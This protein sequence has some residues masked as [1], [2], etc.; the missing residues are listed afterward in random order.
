MSDRGIHPDLL[1]E[2]EQQMSLASGTPVKPT[3]SRKGRGAAAAADASPPGDAPSDEPTAVAADG[4][5]D[6]TTPAPEPAQ[7]PTPLEWL[8]QVR[9]ASDPKEML[10]L[11]TRNLPKEDLSRDDVLAG[12]IGDLGN[13]RARKL[14][15]D[16]ERS[17]VEKA[18]AEAY[19]KGDLY[20]LGQ[21][22]AAELEQQRA[23]LKAQTEAELNPYMQG[24]RQ[25]QSTLPEAVQ[26]AVQGRTY[27]DFPAYLRAVQEAAIRHGVEDEIGKRTNGLQKAALSQTVGSEQSPELDGGPAQA[28]REITDAQIA[29]MTLEEYDRHF[30]NQG[31][32][33]PGV[34]VRLERGIDLR[35][36]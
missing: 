4:S 8:D 17:R 31:R 19:E 5:G 32:P 33:K 20:T 15:E 22:N 9:N 35:Q 23:A 28:Y 13:Q 12:M 14:L 25:F 36:R 21:L 6:D 29:A 1:E 34:R 27:P 10:S 7:T 18:R 3:R 11:L 24:V 30:D 2:Y 26:Q 16:Q